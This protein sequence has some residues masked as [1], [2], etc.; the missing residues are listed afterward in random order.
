M[1]YV[2]ILRGINIGGHKRILM[3]DLKLLFENNEFINTKTYIQ[4]GNIVFDYKNSNCD[5]VEAKIQELIFKKY[6]FEVKTI[7]RDQNQYNK[8]IENNSFLKNSKI[9]TLYIS[10]L[11]N[12]PNKVLVDQLMSYN[13][14]NSFNIIDKE[15]HIKLNC[16]YSESELS[17]Q[18]FEKKLKVD[19]TTRNMKTAL[20]IQ[21]LL[22]S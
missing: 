14:K 11:K 16:N 4:S 15:V 20:K 1:K 7:V 3:N 2:A 10:F 12:E 6:G 13:F 8:L 17:T 21:E 19:A 22:N 18:Y 5:E 9:E